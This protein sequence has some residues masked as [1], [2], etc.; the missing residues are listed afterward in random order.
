MPVYNKIN[1]MGSAYFVVVVQ[2]IARLVDSSLTYT[3]VQELIG[4][5]TCNESHYYEPTLP[6]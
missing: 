1:L 3:P 4:V 2:F 6:I 5:E